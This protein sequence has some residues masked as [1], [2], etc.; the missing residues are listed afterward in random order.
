[1]P[2]EIKVPIDAP[3][4]AA[5][6]ELARSRGA[7]EVVVRLEP[8]FEEPPEA[9]PLE[10]EAGAGAG[11][12]RSLEVVGPPERHAVL[13]D[14]ALSTSDAE[15]LKVLLQGVVV[16]GRATLD[17]PGCA[18]DDCEVR[19]GIEVGHRGAACLRG[20]EVHGKA[21]GIAVHGGVAIEDCEVDGCAIAVSLYGNAAASLRGN[22]FR[23]CRAAAVV[24][25]CQM[26]AEEGAVLQLAPMIDESNAIEECAR[27][28]EVHI[29]VEGATALT[30]TDEWPLTPSLHTLR[31]GRGGSVEVEVE[32]SGT[33]LRVV[34]GEAAPE[35]T[36]RRKRK[37]QR[38]DR[39]E[40]NEGADGVG[41][42]SEAEILGPSW[43]RQVLGLGEERVTPRQVRAAYR[44]KAREVHPD[45]QRQ[46]APSGGAAG[47]GLEVGSEEGASGRAGSF[48]RLTEAYE[49]LLTGVPCDEGGRRR[50]RGGWDAA[51]GAWEEALTKTEKKRQRAA[52]TW[53][54]AGTGA[55]EGCGSSGEGQ[56]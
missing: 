24:L 26:E 34:G 43:A 18:L 22:V 56:K 12:F 27:T 55:A 8:D 19:H 17:G 10:L 44:R 21:I 2:E 38:P 50:G 53:P 39:A 41:L 48:H 54:A 49:A 25:H 32:D 5:A 36:E 30:F 6:L 3:S 11:D 51:A 40:A 52:R 46:R 45:K 35:K 42:E 29:E 20:C 1:M 37:W 7:Q 9:W 28:F 47:A 15:G 23:R 14:V 33:S 16:R 13:R 4:V 31:R